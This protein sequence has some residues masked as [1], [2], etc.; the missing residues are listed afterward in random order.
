MLSNTICIQNKQEGVSKFT[1]S[2]KISQSPNFHKL[3]ALLFHNFFVPLW[4]EISNMSKVQFIP[5]LSKE[6]LLFPSRIDEDIADDAP[7]RIIDHVLDKIDISNILKLYH[8][9]GVMHSIP[10]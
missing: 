9:K 1:P 8:V 4:K 3:G 7:V 5:N 2:F 10:V 6:I